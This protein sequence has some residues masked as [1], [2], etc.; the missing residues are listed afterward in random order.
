[1]K[2]VYRDD[3]SAPPIPRLALRPREA[4][5]ALGMSEKAVWDRSWPRGDIPA[6]KL[7]SRVVYFVHQLQAW[8]DKELARQQM[9]LGQ[10]EAE[11]GDSE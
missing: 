10:A 8:A 1:M 11:G 9:E 5:I 4:A 3:Q 7:G 6:V 2:S